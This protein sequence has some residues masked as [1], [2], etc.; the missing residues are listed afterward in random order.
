MTQGTEG[1]KGDLF[2]SVHADTPAGSAGS[3]GGDRYQLLECVA[4][5]PDGPAVAWRAW[6]TLLARPVTLTVV[7]PG[8]P[9]A[10]GFLAHAH[11]I[12]MAVH[13]ALARVY[14]AVD[15][16]TRAY[17]VSEWVTGTPL[18]GLLRDGALDP[19]AAAVTICRIADGV[20]AAHAAG[21]A[22]GSVHPDHVVVT[23]GGTVT[24]AQVVGDGRAD[25]SDDVRGLGALLYAALTAQW[26]LHPTG[27][28]AALRPAGTNGS[29]LLTPRQARGGVPEDLSTLSMRALQA[30]APEGVRSAA[31]IATV[32]GDRGARREQ[33]DE[34]FALD[35]DEQPSGRR[36]R[37]RW[38]TIAVP[39]A[40]GLAAIG[41]LAYLLG[42]ALGGV[43]GSDR[44]PT[45]IATGA[46]PTGSRGGRSEPPTTQ[47]LGPAPVAAATLFDPSPSS[48]GSEAAKI[49]LSH[50]GD[51][52]TSW[53][54]DRYKRNATFG[55]LK[56]G[57]GIAF[58]LGSPTTV[59]QV[60]ISTGQPGFDVE[61]RAGDA[62][63]G[64]LDSYR[65]VGSQSGVGAQQSIDVRSTAT[66]RYYVVW[67]T[68]LVPAPDAP[69]EYS[70][71]L[72]EVVF[73]R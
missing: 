19:D 68:K 59:K 30:G 27:G 14:D 45:P 5:D 46:G 35:R 12:S 18:T 4:G 33:D 49:D 55:N 64:S 62:P 73:R 13:P 29:S 11:A 22:F 69:N 31:A 7:K 66:A 43:S 9:A 1:W 67:I 40:A 39:F 21:V 56:Q 32:L 37:G 42:S 28:A 63:N 41:L 57:L 23:P 3:V 51:P 20:A 26:P 65:V 25:P 15:E 16:G 34:L 70:A 48:D 58:D 24:L 61:I 52:Q 71:S 6:D 10:A 2:V 36:R 72:S 54:T 60:Q 38:L 47:A 44:K 8:G 17:V 53:P 50:D